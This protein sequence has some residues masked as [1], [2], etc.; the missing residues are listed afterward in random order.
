MLKSLKNYPI[1]LSLI[2]ACII[3]LPFLLGHDV[4]LFDAFKFYSI[5]RI[6]NILS[7]DYF[8]EV[9]SKSTNGPQYRPLSFFVYSLFSKLIFQEHLWMYELFGFS[10]FLATVYGTYKLAL[11]LGLTKN[12]SVFASLIYIFNTSW[13]WSFHNDFYFKYHLTNLIMILGLILVTKN[14]FLSLKHYITLFTFASVA[15]LSHEGSL[16][17]AYIW[18]LSYFILHK[19]IDKYL[20][21]T[22][23]PSLMYLVGRV[24][25]FSIPDSGFMKVSLLKVPQIVIFYFA[26]SW[27]GLIQPFAYIFESQANFFLGLNFLIIT[28][29][30]LYFHFRLHNS[31]PLICYI[32]TLLIILPFSMLPNHYYHVRAIWSYH[33]YG[34][35]F[36]FCIQ[37]LKD[38][39]KYKPYIFSIYFIALSS[40]FYYVK[41]NRIEPF[42]NKHRSDIISFVE[43]VKFLNLE[44]KTVPFNL[45]INTPEEGFFYEHV[46]YPQA[47][48]SFF[49]FKENIQVN[50]YNDNK[51]YSTYIISNRVPYRVLEISEQDIKAIDIFNKSYNFKKV[52]EDKSTFHIK[53]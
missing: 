4:F 44:D 32:L 9:F 21:I 2:L 42:L 50:I 11:L 26:D 6:P 29:V 40:L 15:I 30:V 43:K 1:S 51:H 41:L 53:L 27:G 19:K 34:L 12:L 18:A 45:N 7:L 13:N 28:S 3:Y 48:A 23:L 20:L 16:T 14:K 22:L 37:Q 10:I 46:Y 52:Y 35:A 8:V 49:H 25:I 17:F 36:A 47:L 31:K 24:F 39:L 5:D 38:K 33:F